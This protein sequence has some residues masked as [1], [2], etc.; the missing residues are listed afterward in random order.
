MKL[1]G[2]SSLMVGSHAGPPTIAFMFKD[3]PVI[4]FGLVD[5]Y[6]ISTPST[7]KK[8]IKLNHI[9]RKYEFDSSPTY[10]DGNLLSASKGSPP[11]KEKIEQLVKRYK[12]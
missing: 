2:N 6:S 9:L 10:T 3:L 11:S 1:I 8:Y 5:I 4:R 12:L 7:L